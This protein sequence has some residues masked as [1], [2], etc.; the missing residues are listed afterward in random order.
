MPQEEVE[1][2]LVYSSNDDDDT[3]DKIGERKHMRPRH[4]PSKHTTR[5]W[6]IIITILVVAAAVVSGISCFLLGKRVERSQIE[7]DWFSPPGRIDHTFH[8]RKQFAMRPSN[9]SQKYW[10]LVF[11]RGRGFVQHPTKSPEPMGLAVYHQLHCLDAIRRGYWAA[12]D[13]I[14]PEYHFAP[15]HVRHCI[16]YLRQS[17]M[18]QADTNLEPINPDLRGVTGF[19]FSRKCRDIVRLMGWA[20]K[21]RTH[22]QTIHT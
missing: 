2:E 3:T 21:W 10:N 1:Y 12:T 20:D 22:N 14:E 8:Y 6:L 4:N 11:P 5:F 18:C 13:G 9:E 15:G 16:D 17:I 19:G 7:S